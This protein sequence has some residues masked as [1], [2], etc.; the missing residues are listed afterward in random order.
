MTT[1]MKT[2]ATQQATLLWIRQSTDPKYPTPQIVSQF[3]Q[4]SSL[5]RVSSQMIL[6]GSGLFRPLDYSDK[7]CS[8]KESQQ[9]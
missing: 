4:V 9:K 7:N 5:S 2:A 3:F 1:N 8:N 6:L